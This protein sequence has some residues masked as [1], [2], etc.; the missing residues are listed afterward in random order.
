MQWRK[1]SAPTIGNRIIILRPEARLKV[2]TLTEIPI[3][4][5]GIYMLYVPRSTEDAQVD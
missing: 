2:T 1:E 4:D 3:F 5:V